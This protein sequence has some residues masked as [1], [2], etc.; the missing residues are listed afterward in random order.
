LK[1]KE[2]QRGGTIFKAKLGMN[3][4]AANSEGKSVRYGFAAAT[5]IISVL[6]RTTHVFEGKRQQLMVR[7]DRTT[8]V[9]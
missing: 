9:Q 2:Q 1:R 7:T 8:A 4:E 6:G 3:F 5:F